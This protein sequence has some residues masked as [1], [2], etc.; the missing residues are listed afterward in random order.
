MSRLYFFK[1]NN[2]EKMFPLYE[3]Q[4]GWIDDKGK[5]GY[6][7][8]LLENE[9]EQLIQEPDEEYKGEWYHI[10]INDSICLQ[11]NFI[12]GIISG[13]I[14]ATLKTKA[15]ELKEQKIIANDDLKEREGKIKDH[16]IFSTENKCRKCQGE[17]LT[18]SEIVEKTIFEKP[19]KILGIK[20]EEALKEKYKCPNCKEKDLIFNHAIRYH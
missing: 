8:K 17:L 20:P 7:L 12:Y 6:H 1:C 13:A 10:T 2:C 18:A 3:Y 19:S 5:V 9:K 16:L 14:D 4:S 15:E 11:C